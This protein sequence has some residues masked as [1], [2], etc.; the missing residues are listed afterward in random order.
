MPDNIVSLTGN[1]TRDPELTFGNSGTAIAKFGLAIN[2][3][4][5][6]ASGEWVD[7]DPQF[8]DVTAFGELA[9]NVA[10]S[11]GKGARVL[12]AG[13]LN[14][15]SWET[16]DGDKR[17]KVDVIADSVGPDLRW[18]TAVVTRTEKKS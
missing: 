10:E 6:D 1:A 18:A 13:R 7:G 3:R 2:S 9:E 8:F 5:K 14:Y 11:I 15:S 12:V 17:N 4:K 16:N